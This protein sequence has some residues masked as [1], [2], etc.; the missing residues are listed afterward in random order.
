MMVTHAAVTI[1]MLQDANVVAVHTTA[2]YT[3]QSAHPTDTGCW[4]AFKV[5]DNHH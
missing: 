1:C 2:G 5:S 4:S 3:P